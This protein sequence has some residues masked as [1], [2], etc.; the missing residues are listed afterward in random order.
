MAGVFQIDREIFDN[1]IWQNPAEFRLFFYI[2]G[3]AVWS[4]E[5]IKY[6]D[7]LVQRGQ[8]L[9]SYRNL[10]EDLV[11]TENNAIK[12]YSLSHI[13]KLIDKLVADERIKKEE[14]TL[15]TLFTVINYG[16]YQGF[17]RFDNCDRERRENEERTEQEQNENN[18][19]K[20]NK[21]NNINNINNILNTSSLQKTDN[22]ILKVK[23]SKVKSV[24]STEDKEYKLA[25]YLSKQI[26]KRLDKP[27]QKEDTLQ[28]WAIEFERTVRIDGNDIDEVRDVLVFSQKDPFWQTNI[29]SAAKFR[30]QY[31]TLL[32]QMKRD[33]N[34]V[35]G[36][37]S[38]AK[39]NKFHNFT[40]RDDYTGEDLERI[41]RERFEKRV[42]DLGL[43]TSEEGEE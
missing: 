28:K 2:L 1:S 9:R 31:L 5:G 24:F 36:K 7:L 41:A 18:K 30:K 13:K 26:A 3:N 10:R 23:K 42:K 35:S 20:D 39:P 25:N 27:L 11:Y 12:Y 37:S 38:N 34:K 4:D 17:S 22:K 43:N 16:K 32:S 6:G 21:D 33:A 15:G 8:F 29:M 19:N 14:T 40:Q